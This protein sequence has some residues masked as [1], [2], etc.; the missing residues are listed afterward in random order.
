L[1]KL[2]LILLWTLSKI[3]ALKTLVTLMILPLPKKKLVLIPNAPEDVTSGA[4]VN[5]VR[6]FNTT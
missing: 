4:K 6:A 1:A 3:P 2:A 5:N